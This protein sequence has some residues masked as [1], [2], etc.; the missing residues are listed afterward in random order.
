[1]G[2]SWTGS[3]LERLCYRFHVIW[4]AGRSEPDVLVVPETC[5]NSYP[6]SQPK[7]AAANSKG[8]EWGLTPSLSFALGR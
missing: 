5:T 6:P 3:I 7:S 8:Y 4:S 2:S 1:M